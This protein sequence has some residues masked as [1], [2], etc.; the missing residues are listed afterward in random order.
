MFS[1]LTYSLIS[2]IIVSLISLIGVFMLS[3]KLEKLKKF[4][5]YVISFS[6]GALLG[7]AFI[8][9]LPEAVEEFGFG[10]NISLYFLGGIVFFF[11]IEKVLHWQHCHGHMLE[12]SHVHPFGYTNLIG[13]GFH[14]FL[15]G[16]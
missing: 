14:N 15:D 9:L 2:V 4:L 3:I 5:I 11:F 7:D 12:K 10:L 8:H 16:I 1:P 6:A 13:D